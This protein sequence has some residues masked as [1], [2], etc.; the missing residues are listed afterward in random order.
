[1]RRRLGRGTIF[2]E[3]AE[4]RRVALLVRNERAARD[5]LERAAECLCTGGQL[6]AVGRVVEDLLQ[7]GLVTVLQRR[8][9]RR[10]G[11]VVDRRVLG[12]DRVD[13]AGRDN[14][15]TLGCRGRRHAGASSQDECEQDNGCYGRGEDEPRQAVGCAFAVPLTSLLRS[16]CF[17]QMQAGRRKRTCFVSIGER[18]RPH[19][20]QKSLLI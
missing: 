18:V 20:G 1:M 2:C 5:L 8:R 12:H 13:L 7:A 14:L 3:H 10:V 11:L 19:Q 6:A 15:S 16:G 9:K 4:I 17:G